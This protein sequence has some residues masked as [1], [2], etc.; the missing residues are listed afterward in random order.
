MNQFSVLQYQY[1]VLKCKDNEVA[2]FT[3]DCYYGTTSGLLLL[4]NVKHN[5]K[6]NGKKRKHLYIYTTCISVS[7]L[8][9]L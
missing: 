8:L 9:I 6:R 4:I 1:T 3:V 2:L 5:T 7:I